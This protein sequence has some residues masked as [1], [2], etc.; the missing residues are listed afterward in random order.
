MASLRSL[1]AEVFRALGSFQPL[2]PVAFAVLPLLLLFLRWRGK[3]AGYLLCFALFFLYGWSVL[4]YTIFMFAP[5][6]SGPDIFDSV[7]WFEIINFV[8]AVISGTFNVRSDQVYGNFLLGVPFGVGFPF[9]ARTS[10]RVALLAGLGL[11]TGLELAQLLL[12]ML[13]FRS[14]Y[15]IIDIDDVL[16]VFTGSLAGHAALWIAALL[17]RWIGLAGGARLPV[18]AHFHEVLLHV[19]SGGA[20]PAEAPARTARQGEAESVPAAPAAPEEDGG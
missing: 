1:V 6:V 16:L 10:R 4:T 15:R 9:V 17:Y 3:S 8:P 18:W 2:H 5:S 19:A 12:G 7:R 14:P 11:A 20:P 13:V